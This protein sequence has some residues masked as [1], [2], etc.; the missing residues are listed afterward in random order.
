MSCLVEVL[1]ALITERRISGGAWQARSGA[2]KQVYTFIQIQPPVLL[3]PLNQT[4]Q[5]MN[6][7]RSQRSI[8]KK[9]KTGEFVDLAGDFSFV[10]FGS[11]GRVLLVEAIN[12]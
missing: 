3:E 12:A 7:G 11:A 10:C 8:P 1:L 6:P 4:T 9:S 5:A 2:A